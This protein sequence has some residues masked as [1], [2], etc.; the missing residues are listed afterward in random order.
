MISSGYLLHGVPGSGKTSLIHAVAGALGLDIYVIS[1]SSKGYEL[2]SRQ[3]RRQRT[4]R[5][6]RMNDTTLTN[7]MGRVP[8]R[9][10]VLL[11][12]L[13]AAFTRGVSRDETSTGVPTSKVATA[14]TLATSK[15]EATETDTNS[16]SLSGLLNSLDGKDSSTGR[17][18]VQTITHYYQASLQAKV[19]FSSLRR[20][21]L[22][23][24]C[25]G[26]DSNSPGRSPSNHIER[27]DPALSR[28]GRMDVWIDF[29]HASKWQ[30]ECVHRSFDSKGPSA[31][32]LSQLGASS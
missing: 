14:P 31:D 4:D 30:A 29:K 13:D 2:V 23:D 16:L 28:P 15:K 19:A 26:T 24:F 32:H 6:T 17:A 5:L 1:L 22:S 25:R 18:M 8:S 7:L 3:P 9:C 20:K 10:I 21:L 11:E 27:L 12:D